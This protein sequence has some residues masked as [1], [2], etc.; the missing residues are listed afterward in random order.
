MLPIPSI[1]ASDHV[2]LFDRVQLP[3]QRFFWNKRINHELH[4]ARVIM[5]I[6]QMTIPR[7]PTRLFMPSTH[8]GPFGS[9]FYLT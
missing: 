5:M 7:D 4:I 8:K 9:C 6:H 2:D 3:I 1:D